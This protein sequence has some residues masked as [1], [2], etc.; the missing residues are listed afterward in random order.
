MLEPILAAPLWRLAGDD[1]DLGYRL[2]QSMHALAVSL[3][4][5]PVYL[6][7]RRLALSTRWSLACAALALLFPVGI[8]STYV[9][10]D[11]VAWPFALGAVAAGLAAL[12][13]PGWKPQLL[14]LAL[15]GLATAARV[16]YVILPVVYVVAA[17]LLERFS[18]KRT[19]RQHLCVVAPLAV[20]ALVALAAGPGRVLGYYRGVLDLGLSPL[21]VG[22]WL[23]A[24]LLL[25]AFASGV[26]LAPGASIGF[27][28]AAIR[29][30]SRAE[31]AFGLLAGL[32]ILAL[33][34]EATLYASNGAERFQERY[35]VVVLPLI[36]LAFCVWARRL[37]SRVWRYAAVPLAAALA[38][39]AAAVPVTTFDQGTSKQDSPALQGVAWLEQQVGVGTGAI[40]AAI[41]VTVL[42]ILAAI[43]AWRPRTGVP[44][45]AAGCA[46]ALVTLG[47]ASSV[48][49]LQAADG[50]KRMILDADPRWIDAA[51]MEDVSILQT[52]FSSRPQISAQMFWNRSL[53]RILQMRDSS[54]VDAFGSVP[55]RVAPDGRILARGE[56][57]TGPLLVEEY[58]S[59]AILDDATLVRRVESS[60]LWSSDSPARM[61]ALVAGRYLDGWLGLRTRITI[62]PNGEHP[63]RGVLRM[64]L[65]LPPDA[66]RSTVNVVGRGFRRTIVVAYGAP[67]TLDLPLAHHGPWTVS[68]KPRQAFLT[69]GGRVVSVLA[70]PPKIVEQ[71]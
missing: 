54:T 62:W 49:S 9:M 59:Y 46:F 22:H 19:V 24:D 31:H 33:L 20:A 42:A 16:Q 67:Q 7:A 21:S 50:A 15:A 38:V 69:N 61:T 35:L 36:P 5:V 2:V 29:P 30:R 58:S 10:A 60:A 40:F 57:V 63:R 43:A 32:T 1:I 48:G 53:S 51:G 6:I 27:L 52:P 68:V 45:A 12:E 55:A 3:V 47:V 64:V 56:P 13:R 66:P 34:A 44:V 71:P 17:F 70:S 28:V 18:V 37:D 25:L 39:A 4:A 41:A 11:A 14:F 26:A 23:A 65:R 8:L